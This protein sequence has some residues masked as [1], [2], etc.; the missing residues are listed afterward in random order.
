MLQ[1][2]TTRKATSKDG[3]DD[4]KTT[5]RQETEGDETRIQRRTD[6]ENT[7]T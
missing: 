4:K 1:R 3:K 2:K 6:S 7:E 5:K